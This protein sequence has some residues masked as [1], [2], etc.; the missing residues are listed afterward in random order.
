M[1]DD[2]GTALVVILGV[3]AVAGVLLAGGAWYLLRRYRLPLHAVA[4]TIASLLY[5][6]SPVDA[7]PEVPLGP[8]G[9]VDDLTVI[10]AAALYLR[11]LVG[12]RSTAAGSTAAG[13]ARK[14]SGGHPGR[15]PTSTPTPIPTQDQIRERRT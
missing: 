14:A 12:A 13:S 11:R 5:V 7:V 15:T 1:S 4:T 6:I 10:I 2:L 8:V 3:I 9:L